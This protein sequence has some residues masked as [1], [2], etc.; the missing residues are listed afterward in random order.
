MDAMRIYV[1]IAELA[2]F[3]KAAY[4]LGLP[5]ASISTAV[6]HLES[7]LGTRGF[8]VQ[9]FMDWISGLLINYVDNK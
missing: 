2:S 1:W 8:R 4:G 6:Q 5:K 7:L 3:T 9:V